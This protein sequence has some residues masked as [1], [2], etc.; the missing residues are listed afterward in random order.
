M[1]ENYELIAESRDGQ[2]TGAS[3]RLRRTGKIPAVIYGAGKEPAMVAFDHDTI[4]HLLEHEAFHTSVL[5][6]K[7]HNETE[8]AILRDVQLHPWKQQILHLDFQRISAK[9]K[10]HM[11]V[12]LHF[13]GEEIAPGVKQQGGIVS[14]LMTEVDITCLP[15]D[16]PEYLLVDIS[17]LHIGDSI[18]L[19][20]L[21]IPKGV[22]ITS[23]AH[24]GDDHAVVTIVAVRGSDEA[25]EEGEAEEGGAAAEEGGEAGGE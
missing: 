10:L 23:M 13:E 25:A 5:K 11:K 12:P 15:G 2:G 16:L 19:S 7:H 3:R 18:H 9:E 6:V 20:Q 8:Q 1:S 17:G 4:F 21:D 14:H 24:G 22:E